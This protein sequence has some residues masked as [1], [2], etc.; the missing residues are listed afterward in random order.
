MTIATA[1]TGSPSMNPIM[2]VRPHLLKPTPHESRSDGFRPSAPSLAP[3]TRPPC[4]A[5]ESTQNA[6]PITTSTP[7]TIAI[8]RTL[9][10]THCVNWSAL[11]DETSLLLCW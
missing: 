2:K 3:W 1:A 11:A 5:M 8:R 4:A 7:A 6:M 10:P 9:S